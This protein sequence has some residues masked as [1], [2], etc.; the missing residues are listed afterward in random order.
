[1]VSV[2]CLLAFLS[3]S[4]LSRLMY[5]EAA[6]LTVDQCTAEETRTDSAWLAH[7]QVHKSTDCSW[8]SV[9]FPDSDK[10]AWKTGE[11]T[12]PRIAWIV[13]LVARSQAGTVPGP[14]L[15]AA[16]LRIMAEHL[17]KANRT[18]L[19]GGQPGYF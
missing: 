17:W 8:G 6:V 4:F 7:C 12:G 5:P 10:V 2:N 15:A 1:M 3:L 11:E 14:Q 18:A 13:Q 19:C 16:S 9:G